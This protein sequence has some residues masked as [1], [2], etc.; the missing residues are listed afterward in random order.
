MQLTS[1]HIEG[2]RRFGYVDLDFERHFTVIVGDNETG[3]STVLEALGLVLTGLHGGR[4]IQYAVDPYLFN[5]EQVATFFEQLRAGEES[6]PPRILIEAYLEADKD[7]PA[8]LHLRGT[9]NTKGDDCPGLVITIEV[10]ASHTEALKEYA[11]DETNPAVVPVEYY[12]ASWRSF[13]GNSVT[14][15]SVPV[16]A[17]VIDTSHVR[18]HRGPSKY[19]AQT[20]ED[21]LTE[22]QR[23]ALSLEYKKLRHAFSQEPG[24]QAINEHLAAQGSSATEKQLSVQM[25]LSTKT[26]WDSSIAAHLDDLPFDCAGKGEQCRIQLRLAVA[27][28]VQSRIL[29]IEE[30]ENHLSHSN[31]N[32]LLEEIRDDCKTRQTV[33]AT[34]SAY[35]LNKLGIDSLRLLSADGAPTTL[36]ALPP[37]T[38]DY[39]MK[40]PGYDT[41]R[42]ILARSTILVEGPSDELVVQRAYFDSQGK[43]PL[44]DG[45]DV[46]SVGGLAFKR[47]LD[48]AVL[49]NLDVRVVTDNDRD[50]EALKKKYA[51]YMGK[52]GS[53]IRL[54]YDEDET[55]RSLEDQL[56]K[57][58]SLET[59]NGILETKHT[60]HEAILAYMKSNKTDCAL[61]LFLTEKKWAA[62]KYIRDAID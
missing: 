19:L 4:L 12:V 13:D 54:C 52:E 61:K 46:V 36:Q 41:L 50:V 30:P 23:R 6:P 37:D 47:F 24:V 33:V 60:N 17:A 8:I 58:N 25:D 45:V 51:D 34:H 28:S 2:F 11:K 1:A 32:R 18:M 57:A 16:K 44:D 9:N 55:Y 56:L 27:G 26:T 10:D 43:L 14:K 7:E 21:I 38:R 20:V 35:V 53:R 22:E 59:L 62:P 40:L 49:L 15:R 48:I 5:A 42:V 3:K 31:L 39:F 29:L